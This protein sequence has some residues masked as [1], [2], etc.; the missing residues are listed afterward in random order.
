MIDVSAQGNCTFTPINPTTVQ[1]TDTDRVSLADGTQNVT[2][3]CSCVDGNG[4]TLPFIRWFN[5]NKDRLL[6]SGHKNTSTGA[7]YFSS[8]GIRNMGT[9][10]TLVI[11]TLNDS[12][13]GTYTCA[14]GNFLAA[15]N[16]TATFT[17]NIFSKYFIFHCYFNFVPYIA[18]ILVIHFTPM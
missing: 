16:V 11:P 5:T 1:L 4:T 6:F 12:Y 2:I 15:A 14:N 13:D 9:T 10:A 7:P 17:F 18:N 8:S 3:T